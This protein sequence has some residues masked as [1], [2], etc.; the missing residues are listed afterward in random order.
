M[1]AQGGSATNI[2][3]L[4]TSGRGEARIVAAARVQ[5]INYLSIVEKA[6]ASLAHNTPDTRRKVYDQ[7]QGVVKRHLRLM[8]L[9]QPIVELEKLALDLAVKKIEREW[10]V[11]QAA[12]KV[13][14]G[15]P[16]GRR[17][18]RNTNRQARGS[19]A[20]APAV[21][22]TALWLRRM[23]NPIGVAVALPI[24]ATAVF[25]VFFVDNANSYRSLIDG[26]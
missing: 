18:K 9:P 6:V 13:I 14:A 1:G 25:F 23:M 17:I 10:R 20:R 19:P 7:A 16:P 26:P 21:P 11:R 8:R 4:N 15:D 3:E 12:K 2:V 24:I 5:S 22:G